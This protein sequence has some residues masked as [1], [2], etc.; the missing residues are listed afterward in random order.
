MGYQRHSHGDKWELQPV[1]LTLDAFRT[2]RPQ[3]F[4]PQHYWVDKRQTELTPSLP[5]SLP[6]SHPFCSSLD[7]FCSFP[8]PFP[9]NHTTPSR[10]IIT[11]L[12]PLLR[13]FHTTLINSHLLLQQKRTYEQCPVSSLTLHRVLLGRNTPKSPPPPKTQPT[14]T[15]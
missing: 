14:S 9:S 13:Y 7:H 2:Q 12:S 8:F 1:L 3:S 11:F 5:P 15:I 10:F 4:T 6:S